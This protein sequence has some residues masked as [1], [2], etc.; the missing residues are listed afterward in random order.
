MRMYYREADDSSAGINEIRTPSYTLF[1]NQTACAGR[2]R[3]GIS[4]RVDLYQNYAT[5]LTGSTIY[6]GHL[7][8]ITVLGTINMKR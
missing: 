5:D 1:T 7:V 3:Y 8:M 4:G 6:T 2:S